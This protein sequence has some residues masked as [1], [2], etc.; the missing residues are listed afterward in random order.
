[1]KNIK[2]VIAIL[3]TGFLTISN[4]SPVLAEVTVNWDKNDAGDEII[5]Q[6]TGRYL[7]GNGYGG[8][9]SGSDETS[10]SAN[11]LVRAEIDESYPVYQAGFN[12]SVIKKWT[13]DSDYVKKQIASPADVTVANTIKNNFSTSYI[14]AYLDGTNIEDARIDEIREIYATTEDTT[15]YNDF[16]TGCTVKGINLNLNVIMSSDNA[17]NENVQTHAF[18]GEIS[19]DKGTDISILNPFGNYDKEDYYIASFAVRCIWNNEYVIPSDIETDYNE[20][21]DVLTLRN[22][23]KYTEYLIFWQKDL[24]KNLQQFDVEILD[25]D[26]TIIR[27]TVNPLYSGYRPYYRDFNDITADNMIPDNIKDLWSLLLF[28]EEYNDEDWYYT[29]DKWV[30]KQDRDAA[31]TAYEE[32]GSPTE[33]LPVIKYVPSYTKE[34]RVWVEW[35]D[36]YGNRLSKQDYKEGESLESGNVDG[37]HIVT[38]S[39]MLHPTL[40]SEYKDNFLGWRYSYDNG[41]TWSEDHIS[42]EYL[43]GATATQ[44]VI[45]R[46]DWEKYATKTLIYVDYDGREL[47]RAQVSENNIGSYTP[48]ANP[49]RPSNENTEYTF[50]GWEIEENTDTQIVYRANYRADTLYTITFVDYDGKVLKTAKYKVGDVPSCPA[51]SR[52]GYSFIG[53]NKEGISA[54]SCEITYTAQYKKNSDDSS[55]NSS[56]SSS[57]GTS[58]GNGNGG[59][60]WVNVVFRDFDGREVKKQTV[61]QGYKLDPPVMPS[62]TLNGYQFDFLA[63]VIGDELTPNY[64][65]YAPKDNCTYK[66]SYYAKAIQGSSNNGKKEAV[67]SDSNE[68]TSDNPSNS[69]SS[70]KASGTTKTA[71]PQMPEVG[72]SSDKDTE[73]GTEID[74]AQIIKNQDAARIRFI[75]NEYYGNL[76][77]YT[78]FDEAITDSER[79]T[80]QKVV[81][82]NKEDAQKKIDNRE[83]LKQVSSAQTEKE[84]NP[85]I[86]ASKTK[87]GFSWLYLLALIPIILLIILFII[88]K[89][90]QDEEEEY[91]EYDDEI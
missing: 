74:W 87:T 64:T 50:I 83:P 21:T 5:Y 80:V 12:P 67:K 18:T 9:H 58:S 25:K 16:H 66:A 27:T 29:F 2:K 89:K 35:Q 44:N 13:A 22:V 38:E 57:S 76:V 48:P 41:E 43:L 91:E 79:E 30:I 14:T 68:S 75:P 78:V 36:V 70:S 19:E 46:A 60:Y 63:W 26:D 42:E 72:G 28:R 20:E 86:N 39:G 45:Y 59:S 73:K 85:D 53:W 54:V 4:I 3:T 17:C 52:S 10:G 82:K 62:F 49:T 47:H 56:N 71:K 55:N 32:A 31:L 61:P 51:P 6:D 90:K 88:W 7:N 77:D 81:E 23:T 69:S 1:M 34:K 37:K 8:T 40:S 84:N 65:G 11:I 15:P 33:S 24:R